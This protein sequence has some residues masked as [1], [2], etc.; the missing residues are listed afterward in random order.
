MF[1]CGCECGGCCGGLWE[2]ECVFYDVLIWM[3]AEGY[4]LT[5]F[6]QSRGG[7]CAVLP[8]L[9]ILGSRALMWPTAQSL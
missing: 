2:L 7:G 5:G 3:T 8:L 4:I 1:M 6:L 9:R